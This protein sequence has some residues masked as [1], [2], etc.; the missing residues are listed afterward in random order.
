[1]K[2]ERIQ[3]GSSDSLDTSQSKYFQKAFKKGMKIIKDV[4]GLIVDP[5]ARNCMWGDVR[6]DLNTNTKAQY[7]MEAKEFMKM[8]L[9]NHGQGSMKCLLFDPPFS[10]R[11]LEKYKKTSKEEILNIYSTPG[12][13]PE[14]FSI[15]E[16]LL[17]PGGI[18]IKLGYNTSRPLPYL[19]LV[20]IV[21]VNFGGNRNDVICSI[22]RNPNQNLNDWLKEERE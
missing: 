3:G 8:V 14:F 7:H 19:E 21:I 4:Q 11:Q 10:S 20:E 12:Y 18:I 6:N 15:V 16:K 9:E 13:I 17:A 2:I 22:W 1:M 5:F